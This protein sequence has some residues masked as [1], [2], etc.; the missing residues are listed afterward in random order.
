MK[1]KYRFTAILL[2]T[3]AVCAYLLTSIYVKN[4]THEEKDDLVVVTS[5]YPMYIATANVVGDCEGI[6]VKNLSEPQTGCLHDFQL[7]PEDMKLLSTADV[8]VI[9]G[10]GMESFLTDVMEQYPNL[11]IV[12]AIEGIELLGEE[13]EA[14]AH[15]E[16]HAHEDVHVEEHE[17]EHE[18]SHGEEQ[19]HAHTHDHEE[20]AHVWMS[21]KSYR[22]Q[23]ENITT[24][25]CEMLEEHAGTEQNDG[26][27][28]EL[29]K[30][31][32]EY[33]TK[34]AELQSQQEAVLQ[35]AAGSEVI[36]FHDAYA[37]VALDYGLDVCYTL[38]LDEERQVSAGEVAD[39]L[40]AVNDHGVSRIFVE[41]LYG[42]DLAATI[43]KEADVEV[44]YLDTL[45][46]G[47]YDLD[48][49]INGMQENIRIL[50]EAFGVK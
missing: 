18:A 4:E 17:E 29:Q 32:T 30:N 5:F 22:K 2:L 25:L 11:T 14:D 45:V 6:R 26:K 13:T 44:Y 36:S 38:N 10:G 33:D 8:F 24:A 1:N 39:V 21:V 50:Q 3:I 35:A 16:E 12:E 43:Q 9:N 19:E 46:R 20:N 37:Y 7:T 48:S 49:Y 31:S 23:V 41:E 47:E 28:A 34:L 40:E 15:M 42:S 27:V